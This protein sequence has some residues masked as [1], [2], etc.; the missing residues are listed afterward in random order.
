MTIQIRIYTDGACSNNG[1]E[2]AQG[3]WAAVIE[4]DKKQLRISA[5]EDDTTNQR[6]ELKAA[7]KGLE[8][9]STLEAA[10]TL[11]T[12]SKYLQQGC[13]KW[14]EGWKAKGW[15]RTNGK[16]VVNLDLWMEIDALLNKLNVT[17]EWVK[18]HSGHRMNELA[19]RLAVEAIGQSLKKAYGKPEQF[20]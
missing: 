3:G 11:T 20:I 7:I 9:I 16:P 15:K 19:D 6:M 5:G 14:L 2:N 12:D 1:Q 4:N 13:M 18:A 10:V 8:C 17:V